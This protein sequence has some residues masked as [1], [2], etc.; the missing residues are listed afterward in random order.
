MTR[1]VTS[2]APSTGS[3]LRLSKGLP[4]PAS[5]VTK[6]TLPWPACAGLPVR[7]TQTGTGY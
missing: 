7:G 5:P 6:Q 2:A 3:G 4:A 1:A